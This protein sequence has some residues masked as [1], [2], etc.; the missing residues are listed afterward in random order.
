MELKDKSYGS[1]GMMIFSDCAVIPTPTTEQ[2]ADIAVSAAQSC[3]NFLG[4][5]PVIALLSY[6]TKG[7]GGNKDENI[8][9]VRNALELIK[10]KEPG[11]LVDGEMQLDAALVP[12]VT[13]KKAP[14]SPV[15]GFA[16]PIS[17]LSRGCSV[18][19]IV[20]TAAVTLVQAGGK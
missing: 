8:L 9:R 10:A 3:R 5:E 13:D 2:L 7:S 1:N 16:G 12:S 4:A 6:S 18:E 11:L 14:G 20:T 17:D 19:D 15:K